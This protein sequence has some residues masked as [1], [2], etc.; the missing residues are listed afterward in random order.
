[1]DGDGQSADD[2]PMREHAAAARDHLA[3]VERLARVVAASGERSDLAEMDRSFA[4]LEFAIGEMR[5]VALKSI[6]LE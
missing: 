6:K 2:D 5:A 4:L 3:E 1:M